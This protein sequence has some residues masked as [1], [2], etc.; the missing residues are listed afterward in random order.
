MSTIKETRK[1]NVVSVAIFETKGWYK[2]NG[3]QRNNRELG[4][5]SKNRMDIY[6]YIIYTNIY[7]NAILKPISVYNIR[8][9][10]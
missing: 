1:Q 6:I 2:V 4:I 3:E 10:F 9:C 7:E 5:W 8:Q